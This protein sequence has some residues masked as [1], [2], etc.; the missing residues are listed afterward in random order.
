MLNQRLLGLW[1]VQA[2][3][4]TA[5]AS[6]V[7][8]TIEP[9]PFF[10]RMYVFS[11]ACK[12]LVLSGCWPII[13]ALCMHLRGQLEGQILAVVGIDGN[14]GSTPLHMQLLRVKL[15]TVGIGFLKI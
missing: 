8:A 13:L 3:S 10:R 14:D 15:E 4:L 11:K 7:G 1:F 12:K 6:R 9:H 5:E 2:L